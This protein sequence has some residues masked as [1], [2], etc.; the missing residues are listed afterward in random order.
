MESRESSCQH[1][2]YPELEYACITPENA[3][4]YIDSILNLFRLNFS[5][6]CNPWDEQGM[7]D[8]F[9]SILKLKTGKHVAL[10]DSEGNVVSFILTCSAAEE[11]EVGEQDV[12]PSMIKR[13]GGD[14]ERVLY[15]DLVA[16]DS[17][18]KGLASDLLEDKLIPSA[19][20]AYD[21]V[22]LRYDD[23]KPH[24]RKYYEDRWG[25]E[26]WGPQEG[27]NPKVFPPDDKAG[28]KK[29]HYMMRMLKEF[30]N[31]EEEP[32]NEHLKKTLERFGKVLEGENILNSK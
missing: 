3:E 17:K 31:V 14:P 12:F 29:K 23:N 2:R 25:F 18:Y 30:E 11:S 5:E 7:R 13:S 8:Y 21:S 19:S 27:D 4:K 9:L 22:T 32:V 15:V 6:E 20:G 10:Q 26:E 1:E 24:L 16:S 28:R